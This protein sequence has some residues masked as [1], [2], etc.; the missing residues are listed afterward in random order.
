MVE[1]NQ[2]LPSMSSKQPSSRIREDVGDEFAQCRYL[3][4]GATEKNVKWL[5]R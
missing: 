1:G 2:S 5:S 4:V 3:V